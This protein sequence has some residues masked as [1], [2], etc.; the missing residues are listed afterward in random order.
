MR[1]AK[2]LLATLLGR[3]PADDQHVL[4]YALIL[5][6]IVVV[7]ILSL[8]FLGDAVADLISLVGGGVDEVT[9]P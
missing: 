6:L 5:S 9:L 2:R 8:L 1:A 4:E 7:V 3:D